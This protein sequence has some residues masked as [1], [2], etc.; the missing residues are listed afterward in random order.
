MQERYSAF[1]I[2]VEELSGEA[3][4]DIN[5]LG[6][7]RKSGFFQQN[8]GRCTARPWGVKKAKFV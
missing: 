7:E 2:E 5:D 8:M 1:W 6:R 3:L 4:H